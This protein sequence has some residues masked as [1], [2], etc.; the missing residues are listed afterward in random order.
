MTSLKQI[1]ANRENSK[2]STG[3]ITLEGKEAA[4][5]NTTKHGVLSKRILPTEDPGEYQ[6]LVDSLQADLKPVGAMELALVDKV[7]FTLWRQ[8]RLTKAEAA[9]TKLAMQPANVAAELSR[10]TARYGPAEL[11]EDHLEPPDPAHLK[12]CR[13]VIKA[14]ETATEVPAWLLSDLKETAAE[15]DLEPDEYLAEEGGEGAY[16]RNLADWCRGELEKAAQHEQIAQQ[17]DLVR[18]KLALPLGTLGTLTQYQ[19]TLDNQLYK[20]LR[21]LRECQEWRQKTLEA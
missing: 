8:A 15:F 21:S 17:A 4:S 6:D 19:V 18:D 20:A 1:E 5:F 10:L 11:K 9:T 16:L 2:R 14:C 12:W 3:P 13:E 7:A